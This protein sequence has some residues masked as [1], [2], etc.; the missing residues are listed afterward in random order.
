MCVARD[1]WVVRPVDDDTAELAYDAPL[2]F[3]EPATEA[4]V[5]RLRSYREHVGPVH[6]ASLLHAGEAV[7]EAEQSV[8]LVEGAGRHSTDTLGDLENARR[9]DVGELVPP[10]FA[11]QRDTGAQ[12]VLRAQWADLYIGH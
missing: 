2:E 7:D 8:L 3:L 4:E 10:R 12:L 11:L 9:Y 5:P 1:E 6:D